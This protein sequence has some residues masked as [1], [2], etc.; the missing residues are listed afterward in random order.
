MSS[1]A[2]ATLQLILACAVA[3]IT[4]VGAAWGVVRWLMGYIKTELTDV[5]SRIT[6]LREES[7]SSARYEADM[8]RVHTDMRDL[9]NDISQQG[10][11]IMQRLDNINQMLFTMTQ[12]GKGVINGAYRGGDGNRCFHSSLSRRGR[13]DR[14]SVRVRGALHYSPATA[15]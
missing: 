1:E 11:T 13:C 9:K 3:V 5:H 4:A 14:V 10:N 15:T 7:V 8:Q 2:I 6:K 12:K